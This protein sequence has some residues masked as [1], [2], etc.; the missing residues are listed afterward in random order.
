MHGAVM[1]TCCFWGANLSE[2]DRYGIDGMVHTHGVF[3][4]DFVVRVKCSIHVQFIRRS[5]RTTVLPD[6]LESLNVLLGGLGVVW[7]ACVCV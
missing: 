4:A 6:R 3:C 7:H 2:G 5:I 1:T